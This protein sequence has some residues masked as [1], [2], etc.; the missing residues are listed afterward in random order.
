[1]RRGIPKLPTGA[2]QAKEWQARG[3]RYG[4]RARRRAEKHSALQKAKQGK[5]ITALEVREAS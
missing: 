5:V 1:M 2:A 4:R 3:Q